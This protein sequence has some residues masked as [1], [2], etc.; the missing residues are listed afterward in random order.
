MIATP[1]RPIPRART[2]GP[3]FAVAPG[4]NP[5]SSSSKTKIV[6]VPDNSVMNSLADAGYTVIVHAFANKSRAAG[7]A[8]KIDGV[9]LTGDLTD[10]DAIATLFEQID[11]LDGQLEVLVNNAAISV[12]RMSE[13][14][15]RRF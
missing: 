10:R 12:H 7:L 2:V 13:N 4:M 15:P 11:A 6:A 3:P 9:A 14:S 5:K 1:S 8:S